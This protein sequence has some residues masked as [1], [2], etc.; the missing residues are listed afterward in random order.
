MKPPKVSVIIPVYNAESFLDEC[1]QSVL[2]QTYNDFEV[3]LVNDGSTDR[4]LE[5]CTKYGKAYTNVKVVNQ[6]NEGGMSARRTGFYHSDGEW[7]MFVDA[8]DLIP[9]NS[10][11]LLIANSEGTELVVGAVDKPTQIDTTVSLK[12]IR[13]WAIS[14]QVSSTFYAKLFKRSIITSY[15]FEIPKAIYYGEDMLFFIR[16]VFTMTKAPHFCNDVVYT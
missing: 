3:I 12:Q 16:V 1:I 13:E 5:I 2:N 10:I 14:S 15:S 4:S 8:D 9:K 6:R 11:E 7:I